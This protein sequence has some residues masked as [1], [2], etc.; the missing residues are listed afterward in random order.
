M[1]NKS[2]ETANLVSSKTG[3]AVTISGDPVVLGVGNTETVKIFGNGSVGI[4]TNLAIFTDFGS[5][6]NGLQLDNMGPNNTGIRITQGSSNMFLFSANDGRGFLGITNDSLLDFYVNN[7][8]YFRLQKTDTGTTGGIRI[9]RSGVVPYN[10][11]TGVPGITLA[12]DNSDDVSRAGALTFSSYNDD[13]GSHS[14][15]VDDGNM[16]HYSSSGTFAS[17]ALTATWLAGGGLKFNASS[18]DAEAL[19]DYEEGTFS[20]IYEAASGTFTMSTIDDGVYTKIGNTVF[21]TLRIS[22]T[23]TS[24][25]SGAVNIS[26]LPFT[27]GTS[28]QSRNGGTFISEFYRWGTNFSN[29]RGIPVSGTDNIDLYKNDS[30]QSSETQVSTT[31]MNNGTN[32]NIITISGF[33]TVD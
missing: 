7:V 28:T 13:A 17:S 16:Y 4:N 10:F 18:A 27:V 26:G 21:F 31:D 29:F 15:Y 19:D 3:I 8:S 24:G 1:A 20:A 14:L 30:S 33:Y 9:G 32:Q 6:S 25:T 2:R 5:G 11:G 22:S 12:G 23:S